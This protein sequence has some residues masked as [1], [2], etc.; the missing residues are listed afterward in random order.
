MKTFC[1]KY[2]D[3]RV[4]RQGIA[5]EMFEID[6]TNKTRISRI[7]KESLHQKKKD[8]QPN[9]FLMG[10]IWTNEDVQMANEHMKSYSTS[11]VIRAM[12]VKTTMR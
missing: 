12:Q 3:K 6:T 5:W 8:R 9:F 2:A 1:S 11:S 10:K 4:K 7:H